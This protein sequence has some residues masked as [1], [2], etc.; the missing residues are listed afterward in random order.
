MGII[1]PAGAFCRSV[2]A[3]RFSPSRAIIAASDD[4]KSGLA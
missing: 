1:V 3:L 4:R 2:F